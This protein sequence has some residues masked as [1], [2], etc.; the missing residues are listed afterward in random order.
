MEEKIKAKVTELTALRNQLRD[1]IGELERQRDSGIATLLKVE[2]AIETLVELLQESAKTPP[3]SS[4]A[5]HYEGE[6]IEGVEDTP[7]PDSEG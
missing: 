3:E 2:G 6:D 7:H 1:K 5:K 4:D